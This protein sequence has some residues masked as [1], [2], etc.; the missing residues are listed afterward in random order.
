MPALLTFLIY[1]FS[2][3]GQSWT[4]DVN[5]APNTLTYF[6]LANSY[7]GSIGLLAHEE[8]AE[9]AFLQLEVNDVLWLDQQPYKVQFIERFTAVSPLLVAS[10]FIGAE[11]ARYGSLELGAY[12]YDRPG[13]LVLQTCTDNSKG[14]LFVIA[15]PYHAESIQMI[16]WR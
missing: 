4:Y 6:A 3:V 8:N 16:Q 7:Y 9:D 14:R 5:S 1:G 13:A 2:I 12:I 15:Y 10:E 11:G